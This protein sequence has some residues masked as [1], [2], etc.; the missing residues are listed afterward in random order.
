MPREV[1]R[2]AGSSAS[3]IRAATGRLSARYVPVNVC[4]PRSLAAWASMRRSSAGQ[5][6]VAPARRDRDGDVRGAVLSG[7]LVA[8]DRDTA[9]AGGFDGDEREPAHVVD[10]RE[11]IEQFGRDPRVAPEEP[12][13]D[14]VGV[15]GLDRFGQRGTVTGQD[16]ADEDAAP[17]AQ[18]DQPQVLLRVARWQIRGLPRRAHRPA[19]SAPASEVRHGARL[20]PPMPPAQSRRSLMRGSGP[21]RSSRPRTPQR[22]GLAQLRQ[23]MT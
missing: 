20:P 21:W 23:R 3:L 5:A 6:G 14:G 19:M 9:L 2:F 8:G 18:R 22:H 13:A 15:G 4:M 12:A 10:G 16:G 11:V 1:T 7:W 17:I